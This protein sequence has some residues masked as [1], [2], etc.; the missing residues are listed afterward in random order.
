M[1]PEIQRIFFGVCVSWNIRQAFFWVNIIK[2]SGVFVSWNIRTAFFWENI[3]KSFLWENIKNIRNRLILKPQISILWNIR[4]LAEVHFFFQVRAL[5]CSSCILYYSA[6]SIWIDQWRTHKKSSYQKKVGLRPSSMD[7]DEWRRIQASNSFD[8]T[9]DLRKA[10]AN[11]FKRLCTDFSI[12]QT[13]EPFSQV[14]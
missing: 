14:D 5:K 1:F 13:I 12:T 10:F 4:N 3:I 2:F 9:S 7:N 6:S 8:T 11:V